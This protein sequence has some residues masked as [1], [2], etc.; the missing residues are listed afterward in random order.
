MTC[1]SDS[2]KKLA[3]CPLLALAVLIVCV[4]PVS[5]Q[6]M[7][8]DIPYVAEG[9]H[10]QQLDLYA[11]MEKD[12]PTILLVHGGSLRNGD[13]KESPF[14]DICAAF[15]SAGV[16]CANISYRLRPDAQWPAPPRDIAAAFAWLKK[17]IGSR[18]GNPKKI[19]L[20]GHSS[21]AHM[22]ALVSSDEKYLQEAGYS[23][24][25][26]AGTVPIGSI[27]TNVMVKRMEEALKSVPE[28]VAKRF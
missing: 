6:T 12:F 27:M 18:G 17:N 28:R 5:G 4:R 7:E 13:R 19:F 8:V 10:K 22:V 3:T 2:R 26:V 1:G 11:P 15:Q 23:T 24:K 21:G 14:P 9:E 16:G 25:D 20:V